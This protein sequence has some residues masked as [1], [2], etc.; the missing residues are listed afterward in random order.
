M[1]SRLSD[2]IGELE[3]ADVVRMPGPFKRL[4][5]AR[6]AAEAVVAARTRA[7]TRIEVVGRPRDRRPFRTVDHLGLIP[8]AYGVGRSAY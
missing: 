8:P 2:D 1:E 4:A 7:D 6:D 3:A 5:D